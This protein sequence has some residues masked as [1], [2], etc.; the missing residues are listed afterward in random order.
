MGVVSWITKTLLLKL[1][2][3]H[4]VVTLNESLSSF[5]EKFFWVKK[6]DQFLH[7]TSPVED[8]LVAVWLNRIEQAQNKVLRQVEVDFE[9]KYFLL[10]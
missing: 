4:L 7:E 9:R 1:S 2:W 3:F 5:E 10:L 8:L 6:Q